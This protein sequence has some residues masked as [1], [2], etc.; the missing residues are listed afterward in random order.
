MKCLKTITDS[1]IHMFKLKTYLLKGETK[2]QAPLK[3]SCSKVVVCRWKKTL[4]AEVETDSNARHL[5][6]DIKAGLNNSSL[7]ADDHKICS[8]FPDFTR[9]K[10][11]FFFSA[12]NATFCLP[13]PLPV[14]C[15]HQRPKDVQK[16]FHVSPYG[17]TLNLFPF[18]WTALMALKRVFRDTTAP[19]GITRTYSWFMN[20]SVP[21][22]C[23][24]VETPPS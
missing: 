2:W 22:L 19:R 7:C 24:E 9:L 4:Y 13:L 14:T 15:D 23:L 10:T 20:V 1:L 21:G 5:T 17:V 12:G 18:I 6:A 16:S 3:A 8:V 11:T